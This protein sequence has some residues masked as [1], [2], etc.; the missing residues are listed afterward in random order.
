MPR[1]RNMANVERERKNN[2]AKL[3]IK[4]LAVEGTTPRFR[5]LEYG[6]LQWDPVQQ[7]LREILPQGTEIHQD[8]VTLEKLFDAWITIVDEADADERTALNEAALTA[9][10]D[11]QFEDTGR[12]A[13]YN[14]VKLPAE[15][16]WDPNANAQVQDWVTKLTRIL[17]QLSGTLEDI[18]T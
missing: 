16:D 2:V 11:L 4:C 3:L 14:H 18:K 1:T 7:M 5:W 12:E 10:Q 13:W 8:P 6:E 9:L 15:A 17:G